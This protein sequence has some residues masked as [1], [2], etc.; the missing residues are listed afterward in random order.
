MKKILSSLTMTVALMLMALGPVKMYAQDMVTAVGNDGLEKT[1]S[2]DVSKFT[3]IRDKKLEDVLKKMPGIN[4]MD[5][6]GYMYNG[7]FIEKIYVNGLDILE[8]N[9]DPV[10]NMKP[11]DVE[12]LEITENHVSTKV[13]KGMQ[14]SSSAAINVVLKDHA[15]SKWSG[16]IKGG[17][18]ASP[19][20]VN[21]D[22]NA[23]NIGSKLQSTILFKAD[24]TGLDF[25][26]LLNG[27]G[28]YGDWGMMGGWGNSNGSGSNIDFT[29]RQF[30]NVAPSLAPL[31]SERVRFNR[32]G[33]LN[34]G[35]TLKLNNDYQVNF[36]LTYHNDRLTAE[37]EDETTY[38][39]QGGN[40]VV[41][42][43]GENAKSHQND[44]QADITLLANTD[45]KYLRNQLSFASRWN[46]VDK[47][48][49]GIFPNDQRVHTT[50]LL[51]TNDFLMKRHFG[52]SILS[53]NANAGL[54]LRPQDLDVTKT[55]D[56]F[57]QK[58]KASSLYADL[59]LTL[60]TKLSQQ[61]TFSLNGGVAGN[62]R[63]L[64][65]NFLGLQ[66]M[67]VPDI[68][69]KLNI[70]NAYAGLTFT[71]INDR[72]QATLGLPLKYGN[73]DLT[74]KNTG[75][76]ETK[77]KVYFSPSLSAKYQASQN[78]SLSLD[79]SLRNNE[80]NRMELYP[81]LIFNDFRT[82]S[83]GL[84]DI[85]SDHS[86]SFELGAQ[87]SHPKSSV[88][89][90]GTVSY[91]GNTQYLIPIMDFTEQFII[92]GYRLGK[93]RSNWWEG[94]VEISKGIESLKGKIGISLR[95]SIS[96][97]TI[98]RNEVEIP[99]TSTSISVGP[100]INGRLTSWW[101]VN[102]KL[103][104]NANR[105]KMDDEDT[106]SKSKSYTQTLEM[107][108]D[109]W[110]KLNF[111]ILAEHYY[112]EF[113]DDV[114]KHLILWDAKAEYNL[115]DKMQLILSAKNI[116]NQKTYNYTLADSERFTKSYTAYKIR[117]MIIMLS[118]Y[119]KF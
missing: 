77:S 81:N 25:S 115:S 106:S 110:K 86:V 105:M 76:D 1:V 96:D 14:Y 50:P 56:A 60:D 97:A 91:W 38:Y 49:T 39:L 79:A 118:L 59:G 23:I 36:Q 107:I 15:S 69:S 22:V 37:S 53:I 68:N 44:I 55:E 20:L 67:N 82:A 43:V 119:Y 80:V 92:S 16:S 73:Y 42:V 21:A 65:V 78:L 111:S 35:S 40:Q 28:G 71:Y 66:D 9:Y 94:G 90:N 32:S 30:L 19:L 89:I 116:L 70:L 27:F 85:K 83:R 114:S 84:P 112:T 45:T 87:Y 93:T 58:I 48:I 10:Y 46:D 102:Y 47:N 75:L 6:G 34:I 62:I 117:P 12:R 7:M 31:S 24:N 95:G 13:M 103:N 109:P 17:L 57:S 26:N 29:I 11:E 104:F 113:M 88:F 8:G 52:R 5:W 3:D 61:L 100:Y 108:F 72:L 74:D 4:T 98:D 33:V 41:D 99:Y 51:L 64:D 63:K 54:Y 2:Y 18:G 101:N